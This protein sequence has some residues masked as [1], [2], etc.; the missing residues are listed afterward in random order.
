MGK[1]T[2]NQSP[3][4]FRPKGLQ[5]VAT[6]TQG[7]LSEFPGWV[8]TRRGEAAAAP[9]LTLRLTPSLMT[10]AQM[11]NAEDGNMPTQTKNERTGKQ[12]SVTRATFVGVKQEGSHSGFLPGPH[13]RRCD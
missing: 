2:L 10:S 13:A 7:R 6:D 3:D 8:T 4:G 12:I 1:P 9:Q 11:R 5:G